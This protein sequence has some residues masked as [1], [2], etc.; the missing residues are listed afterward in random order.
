MRML[1][2]LSRIVPAIPLMTFAVFCAASPTLADEGRVK[3]PE[4]V[5]SLIHPD[6]YGSSQPSAPGRHP[7]T[8][9]AEP[10][11]TKAVSGKG[12]A[13]G[14][15]VSTK[16]TPKKSTQTSGTTQ[17]KKSAAMADTSERPLGTPGSPT[18]KGVR[19]TPGEKPIPGRK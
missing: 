19:G 12:T 7:V 5:D 6:E 15:G 16:T 18:T 4:P 9:A 11:G 3:H 1:E 2:N 10:A 13:G 8:P 14:A 17:K